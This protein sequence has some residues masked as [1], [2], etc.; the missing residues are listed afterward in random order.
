LKISAS[1]DIHCRPEEVF[2]WIDNPDKAMR[3]QNGVKGGEIIKETPQRTGTT[4]MEEMEEDGKSLVM[5]G[6][7]TDYI[8][9][10][11]ISFHLESKIH[12][13]NVKYWVT[14]NPDKSALYVESEIKWKFPM[15]IIAFFIGHKIKEKIIQQQKSELAELKRLCET[16]G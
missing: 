12:Q 5:H 9:D 6:E 13:V 15:N 7:I 1:I 14:G 3:W 2:T 4:F 10:K 11:S 8:P 16:A